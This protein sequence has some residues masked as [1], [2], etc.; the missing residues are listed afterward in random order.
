M[1][2]EFVLNGT[3]RA[4]DVPPN[5]SLL[6]V[7]RHHC[8]VTS[9]KDG[10][11]PQ[12]QCGACLALING[13]PKTT[14]AV[15]AATAAGAHIHTIE[16]VSLRDG[17]LCA[18]A[19]AIA[20]GVQCGFCIPGIALRATWLLD[21]NPRPSRTAIARAIDGHLCRCT[22]YTRIIDAVDLFARARLGEELPT[23]SAD[24]TVGHSL[25]RYR[26]EDLALGKKPFVA[27]L[28][29]PRML[30]GAIVQSGYA[31]ARV[32]SIDISRAL[33]VP[34]VVRIVTA[35]DVPGDRWYG[36]LERDW[37]AFVAVGEETRCVGDVLAAVAAEDEWTAR[38]VA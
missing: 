30:F 14:C 22:G 8:G 2:L 6:Q 36:L 15:P 35:T 5:L 34:G 13:A 16:G 38:A 11:A 7:L 21:R 27:D 3:P 26:A 19:F 12:G 4:V 31:R 18:R 25:V 37:P 32:R 10:C 28:V 20:A 23:P 17:D 29:R 1:H 24:G 33:S 9:V